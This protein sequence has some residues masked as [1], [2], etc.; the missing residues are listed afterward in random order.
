MS[1][2]TQTH[3]INDN[4][5]LQVLAVCLSKEQKSRS[6]FFCFEEKWCT[7]S[8]KKSD[9]QGGGG[10][11]F[12]LSFCL[13]GNCS[14]SSACDWEW[15]WALLTFPS[16]PLHVWTNEAMDNMVFL[17]RWLQKFPQY[18]GRDL[19]IAGESYAGIYNTASNVFSLV[20][21]SPLESFPL[22]FWS[23]QETC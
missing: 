19:Y 15:W 11:L 5:P 7:S 1:L 18:K 6:F 12:A 20:F 2:R 3:I 4:L 23:R 21:C 22:L 17:Q 10:M 9:T 13:G 8:S 16:P 14:S